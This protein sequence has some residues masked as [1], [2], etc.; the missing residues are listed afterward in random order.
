MSQQVS[1]TKIDHTIRTFLTALTFYTRIPWPKFV[2]YSA[3]LQRESIVYFPLVGWIVGIVAALIFELGQ[4]YFPVSVAILLSM[5]GTVLLTGALHEDGLADCCDGFGAGWNKEQILTIMKDSSIGTYGV[6]GLVLT[7]GLK[8]VVLLEVEPQH[9]ALVMIAGHSLSRFLAILLLYTH[10]YVGISQG[11]KAQDFIKPLSG[12]E[13]CLAGTFGILPLFLVHPIYL[14][15]LFLLL[16]VQQLLGKLFRKKIGGYTG[17]CLGAT[18]QITEVIFYM[19]IL[20]G[21]Q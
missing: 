1:V 14:V 21:V 16:A 4:V 13:L 2:D 11:S 10:E 15:F 19:L 17:D 18:Q 6:L 7:L 5:A 3:D 9:L 8:F 12:K 20:A